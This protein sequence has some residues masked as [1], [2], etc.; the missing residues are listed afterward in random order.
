MLSLALFIPEEIA[1]IAKPAS[2][3]MIE[4]TT[5]SSTKVKPPDRKELCG[6]MEGQGIMTRFFTLKWLGKIE[7]VSFD[8]SMLKVDMDRLGFLFSGFKQDLTCCFRCD[9]RVRRE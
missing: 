6:E 8:L 2:R 1:G 7:I 4:M 5:R 9:E 3:P